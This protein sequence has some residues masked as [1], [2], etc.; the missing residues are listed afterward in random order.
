MKFIHAGKE[1]PIGKVMGLL[2]SLPI[3]GTG[4]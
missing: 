3:T 1:C 4:G 2:S